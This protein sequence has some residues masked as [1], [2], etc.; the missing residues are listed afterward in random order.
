MRMHHDWGSEIIRGSSIRIDGVSGDAELVT[1]EEGIRRRTDA[2]PAVGEGLEILARAA[3]Q[4]RPPQ[5]VKA[6][7]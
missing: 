2:A 7:R 6:P 3:L 1:R 4:V 5:I